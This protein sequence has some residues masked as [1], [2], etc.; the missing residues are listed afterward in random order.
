MTMN[1]RIRHMWKPFR[2]RSQRRENTG[3]EGRNACDLNS[4]YN[5]LVAGGLRRTMQTARHRRYRRCFGAVRQIQ[6]SRPSTAA[7]L[8]RAKKEAIFVAVAVALYILALSVSYWEAEH[9]TV[10][11]FFMIAVATDF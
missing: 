10:F 6:M 4:K 11:M 9:G 2:G 3:T 7:S 8:H 5:D 1:E